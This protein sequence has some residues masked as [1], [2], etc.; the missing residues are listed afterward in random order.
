MVSILNCSVLAVNVRN[1]KD[2]N[3]FSDVVLIAKM[4]LLTQWDIRLES[5]SKYFLI[6]F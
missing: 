1:W 5:L 3:H 6:F 4:L 2:K